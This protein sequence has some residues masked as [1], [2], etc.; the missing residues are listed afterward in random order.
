MAKFKF[1]STSAADAE[2]RAADAAI[3]PLLTAAKIS[4]INVNG[5]PT[6]ATDDAVPLALKIAALAAVNQPGAGDAEMSQMLANN[7]LLANEAT[8]L[9]TKLAGAESNVST[10]T[11]ENA[12]LKQRVTVLES[13]VSNLTA[14]NAELT[15]LRAAAVSEAGRIG[16][17]MAGVNGEISRLCIG[18]N[19]LTDLR[20]ADGNLLPSTATASERQAAADSIPAADKLKAYAGALNAAVQRTGVSLNALP[21]AGASTSTA[22]AKTEL[23]GRA[24]FAA[25]VNADMAKIRGGR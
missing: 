8:A 15:N 4:S 2:I 10:L 12:A 5:K 13:S 11:Q 1:F 6:P 16:G 21:A 9:Q 20:G 22:P 14:S 24:R 25:A 18:A 19:C 7:T 3:N 23:T 17:L